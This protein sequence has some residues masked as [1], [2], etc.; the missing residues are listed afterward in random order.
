MTSKQEKALAM[1]NSMRL[2]IYT[3]TVF[4]KD[5]LHP[6]FKKYL[7][8]ALLYN[9]I[10]RAKC[11]S[12]I[13]HNFITFEREFFMPEIDLALQIIRAMTPFEQCGGLPPAHGMSDERMLIE[14]WDMLR[15]VHDSMYKE[16]INIDD[17]INKPL[18]ADI[19]AKFKI[20]LGAAIGEKIF[21]DEQTWV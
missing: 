18:K 13:W 5:K 12:D 19:E 20:N 2:P 1:L 3:T 4:P 6:E 10:W 7:H 21:L 17:E 11:H 9:S 14:N 8:R 16:Y 15:D